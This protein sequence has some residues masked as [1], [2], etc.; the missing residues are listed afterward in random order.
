M[1]YFLHVLCLFDFI[2]LVVL[3]LLRIYYLS[4]MFYYHVN[5]SVNFAITVKLMLA[6]SVCLVALLLFVLF[7]LFLYGKTNKKLITKKTKTNENKWVVV[8]IGFNVH[9]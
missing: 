9:G 8:C 4:V 1:W 7:L 5:F 3:L 6:T 2:R